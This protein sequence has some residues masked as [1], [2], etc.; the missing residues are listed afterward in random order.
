MINN[1]SNAGTEKKKFVHLL[2]D[3][4]NIQ[5]IQAGIIKQVLSETKIPQSCILDDLHNSNEKSRIN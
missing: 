2:W 5:N 4:Y 1:A 3:R